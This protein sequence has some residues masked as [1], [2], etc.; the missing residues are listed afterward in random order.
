MDKIPYH[1]KKFFKRTISGYCKEK[2]IKYMN[3]FIHNNQVNFALYC[4]VELLC[5]GFYNEL[6]HE[7]LIIMSKYCHIHNPI[8]PKYYLDIYQYYTEAKKILGDDILDL[9]ND[10]KFRKDIEF[11]VIL[12]CKSI[13]QFIL[14]KSYQRYFLPMDVIQEEVE[15]VLK[16]FKKNL[17][18]L[19]KFESF[20]KTK[21]I[22]E[23]SMIYLGFILNN[24]EHEQLWNILLEFAKFI[25]QKYIFEY[26]GFLYQI[27]SFVTFDEKI[28]LPLYA[29]MYFFRGTYIKIKSFK[30]PKLIRHN[31]YKN[32]RN[33]ILSKSRR[34]DYIIFNKPLNPQLY[35]IKIIKHNQNIQLKNYSNVES[36]DEYQ[37]KETDENIYIENEEKKEDTNVEEKEYIETGN[38]YI[39]EHEYEEHEYEEHKH[40]EQEQEEHEHEEQ[41]EIRISI[42]YKEPRVKE[43]VKVFCIDD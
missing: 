40:E 19:T 26:I 7:L 5:S 20:N 18:K 9:R 31:F 25:P 3:D 30:E 6:L 8:L 38:E 41:N 14:P 27:Y 23:K 35:K 1:K 24:P 37:Q 16:D 29:M 32:I 42:K 17:W 2:I 34:I 12:L 21:Q 43:N 28:F 13:K 10:N 4:C 22:E 36:K 33:A 15:D 39:E 11:F